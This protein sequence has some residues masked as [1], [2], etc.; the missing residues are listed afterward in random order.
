MT[1]G[2][3]GDA[4]A[5][6]I[7]VIRGD[8]ENPDVYLIDLST[9]AGMKDGSM[10]LQANDIIYVEPRIKALVEIISEIS[11]IVSLVSVTTSLLSSIYSIYI[12]SVLR[13]Q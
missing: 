8:K 7:K 5:A 13:G 3:G 6:Q 9:I 2:L 10:V 11:P 12:F 4:K 1:G